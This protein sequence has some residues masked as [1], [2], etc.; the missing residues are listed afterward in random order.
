M[1]HMKTSSQILSILG[2]ALLCGCA[3]TPETIDLG[4][5]LT[6]FSE[7]ELMKAP[8]I[9]LPP[10]YNTDNFRKIRMNV[11][12]QSIDGKEKVM[13]AD[14]THT[15]RPLAASQNLGARLQGAMA[16]LNRFSV[17]SDFNRG[18]ALAENIRKGEE[19]TKQDAD[20]ALSCMVTATKEKLSRYTDTLVIYEVDIDYSCEDLKTGDVTFSGHAKGRTARSQF[21]GISGR[22]TGGF[23]DNPE[24]EKQVIEQASLKA[25]VEIA[26]R[27]GNEYPIGGRITGTTATGE[28]LTLDKGELDG[29]G[30]NQMCVVYVNDG[31]VDVPIALAAAFPKK[32][33]S[34]QLEV[35]RWND[36]DTD[37]KPLLKLF[38]ANPKG[39]LNENKVYAVGYGMP[40]PPTWKQGVDDEQYR[41]AK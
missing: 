10:G 38:K 11:F 7:T 18:A 33:G 40:V 30:A 29:I 22:I 4:P 23:R 8:R 32:T 35:R 14:G 17:R 34:S 5:K 28:K 27:L 41:I 25:L 3:S 9:Q 19:A 20:I 39:F 6:T 1:T 21:V 2:L 31:G 15:E 26:N 16:E 24:N 37:A 36:K 12:V 13:N